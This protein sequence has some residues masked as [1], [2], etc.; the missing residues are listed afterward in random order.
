M[1]IQTAYD[2][3]SDYYDSEENPLIALEETRMVEFLAGLDGLEI[4]DLGCGT[5]RQSIRAQQQGAAVTAIDFSEGMLNKAKAKPGASGIKFIRHDLSKKLPFRGKSFDGVISSLVLEHI[6]SLKEVYS[7][8]ARVCKNGAFV[9]NTM[10]HPAMNLVGLEPRFFHP[11][12]GEEVR[13]ASEGHQISDYCNA[14]MLAGLRLQ[15]IE[16]LIVDERLARQSPRARKYLDWPFLLILNFT[17]C[18]ETDCLN[19]RAQP[20][21]RATQFRRTD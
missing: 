10:L 21:A 3:W 13:A 19:H 7:E 8:V 12:S 18:S 6:P 4:L 5:G 2:L 17:V 20:E 16:E 15:N 1:K 11:V 14:G 9:V